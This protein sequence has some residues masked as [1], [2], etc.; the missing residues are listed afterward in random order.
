MYSN[1]DSYLEKE[2]GFP[3][4]FEKIIDN[5]ENQD[6]KRC[7][8]DSPE[9]LGNDQILI[10][11]DSCQESDYDRRPAEPADSFFCSVSQF[12]GSDFQEAEF[13]AKQ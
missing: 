9:L 5:P 12:T 10:Q 1:S 2:L 7:R 6:K 13:F 3:V 8:N 4:E 11:D